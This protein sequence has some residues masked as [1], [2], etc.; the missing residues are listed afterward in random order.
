MFWLRD[1]AGSRFSRD[2]GRPGPAESHEEKCDVQQ[3]KMPIF[4]LRLFCSVLAGKSDMPVG[5]SEFMEER[6]A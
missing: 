1:G 2:P 6:D 3:K 4:S 5:I